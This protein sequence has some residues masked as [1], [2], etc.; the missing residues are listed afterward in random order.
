MQASKIAVKPLSIGNLAIEV[1]RRCN[2]RC[3][4][5]MRGD[6]PPDTPDGIPFGYLHLLLDKVESIGSITFTGGEPSLYVPAITETLDYCKAHSIPVSS[7]Y[8]VTNG[9][10]IPNDF[11][12]ACLSWYVYCVQHS[13]EDYMC[14]VALSKDNFHEPIPH[15]NELILR[16]FSFFCEDKIIDPNRHGYLQYRGR[17]KESF[18]EDDPWVR[19]AP[20]H[21]DESLQADLSYVDKDGFS[22]FDIEQLTLTVNGDLLSECDYAYDEVDAIRVG[23]ASDMHGFITDLSKLA[24]DG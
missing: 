8:I 20:C 5:C 15:D 4:H 18:A 16:A 6:P 22:H 14:G 3:A 19:P 7:F 11:L 23:H 21:H 1:T 13:G 12:E 2:M 10:E 17:A 9:K 24:N